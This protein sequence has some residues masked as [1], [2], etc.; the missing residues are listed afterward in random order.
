[1]REK[2]GAVAPLSLL[3]AR[4]RGLAVASPGPAPAALRWPPARGGCAGHPKEKRERGKRGEREV[5]ERERER[6]RERGGLLPPSVH[7]QR[8]TLAPWPPTAA[9]GAQSRGG[10]GHPKKRGERGVEEICG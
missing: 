4:P 2:K 3:T 7:A 1:M 9:G 10:A 6:E 5:R 8:A